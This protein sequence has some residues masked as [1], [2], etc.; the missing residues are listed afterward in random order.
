MMST[1]STK[2]ATTTS[3]T[4]KVMSVRMMRMAGEGVL[5][6]CFIATGTRLH[7]DLG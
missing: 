3:T 7:F 4:A 1:T 5:D 6:V 2:E